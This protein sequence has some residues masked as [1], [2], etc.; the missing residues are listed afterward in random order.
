MAVIAC[1]PE[2]CREAVASLNNVASLIEE[3]VGVIEGA[4]TTVLTEGAG[5]WTIAYAEDV[6]ALKTQLN[7]LLQMVHEIGS[8]L[9]ST[10]SGFENGDTTSAGYFSIV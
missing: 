4:M 8:D 3:Q 6:E 9:Q 2:A 1:D 7:T 5:H 10:A